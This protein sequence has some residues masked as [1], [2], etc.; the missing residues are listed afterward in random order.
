[1]SA[2]LSQTSRCAEESVLFFDFE[3][4]VSGEF[5]KDGTIFDFSHKAQ[6][7]TKFE[8]RDRRGPVRTHAC[9]WVDEH[10]TH[11]K[12]LHGP[13]DPMFGTHSTRRTRS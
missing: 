3:R 10:H 7:N 8:L 2:Q 4:R 5:K 6:K 11:S 12:G 1:M 9:G 13:L